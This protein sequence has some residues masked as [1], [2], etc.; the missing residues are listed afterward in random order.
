MRG[1]VEV[2][3]LDLGEDHVDGIVVEKQSGEHRLLGFE[4]ARK[5]SANGAAAPVASGRT[6]PV[7]GRRRSVRTAPV[8]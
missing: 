5:H 7:E 3:G 1:M 8:V 2:L 6:A 4:I